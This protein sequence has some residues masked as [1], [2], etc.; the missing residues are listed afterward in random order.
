MTRDLPVQNYKYT[1]RDV[2]TCPQRLVA[3]QHG[4]QVAPFT[5]IEK[6]LLV[7]A[8]LGRKV[9][10]RSHEIRKK[11][12]KRERE[13]EKREREREREERRERERERE[14]GGGRRESKTT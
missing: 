3:V 9:Q 5:Y 14:R 13:R 11:E 4:N 2:L 1:A 6:I 8:L 12:R 7:A 10:R